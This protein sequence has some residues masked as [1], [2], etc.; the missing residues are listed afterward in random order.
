[1]SEFDDEV[2]DVNFLNCCEV[3]V[4]FKNL[5][6]FEATITLEA[7]LRPQ[8]TLDELILEMFALS[9]NNQIINDQ[10][11]NFQEIFLCSITRRLTAADAFTL[12]SSQLVNF[13]KCY[14]LQRHCLRLFQNS[15]VTF[16]SD[17][18]Q[19][20]NL[21]KSKTF[22]HSLPNTLERQHSLFCK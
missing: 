13:S 7:L 17:V 11:G 14:E 16:A 5:F 22:L 19:V 15:F 9:G 2:F 12:I 1:M 10:H 18:N 20:Q 8:K 6:I 21:R 4:L 3:V